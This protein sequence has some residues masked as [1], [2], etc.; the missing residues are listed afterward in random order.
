M[1][2]NPLSNKDYEELIEVL[3]AFNIHRAHQFW[4]GLA[5]VVIGTVLII[6]AIWIF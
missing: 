6:L 1:F 4:L 5:G 3:T 2:Q